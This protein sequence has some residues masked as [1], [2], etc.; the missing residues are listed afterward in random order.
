M[1]LGQAWLE[2]TGFPMVF[3]VFAAHR[4][5]PAEKLTEAH[6][7]LVSQLESFENS[8]EARQSVV[9]STSSRSGFSE[10]RI[11]Q[12]FNE[13]K[14]RLDDDGNQGLVHFLEHVCGVE[15]Y[16]IVKL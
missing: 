16:Q 1:D 2:L 9:K 10:A 6:Q 8:V 13:V 3:A 15:N 4:D 12:Y 5:S 7:L 14:L 11:D